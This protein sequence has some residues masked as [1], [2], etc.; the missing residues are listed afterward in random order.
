MEPIKVSVK[1]GHPREVATVEEMPTNYKNMKEADLIRYAKRD[2]FIEDD[3]LNVVY[4]DHDAIIHNDMDVARLSKNGLKDAL[5][6]EENFV[7]ALREKMM[8][9]VATDE[10]KLAIQNCGADSLFEIS[11]IAI[12]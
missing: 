6:K 12:V 10:E 7:K 2:L 11:E 9:T 8:S 1:F 3:G 4:H 5:C